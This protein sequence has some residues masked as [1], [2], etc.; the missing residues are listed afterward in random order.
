MTVKLIYY[1]Y[2]LVTLNHQIIPS[3]R[4]LIVYVDKLALFFRPNLFIYVNSTHFPKFPLSRKC[5]SHHD[6]YR[7]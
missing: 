1:I 3:Y 5:V 6:L 2:Q 4:I 7:T